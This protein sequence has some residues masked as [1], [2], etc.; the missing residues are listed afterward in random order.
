MNNQTNQ[1]RRLRVLFGRL[2]QSSMRSPDSSIALV[3]E[4]KNIRLVFQLELVKN[5]IV[6][7]G[8]S[9]RKK[10]RLEAL[11]VRLGTRSQVHFLREEE[12][13]ERKKRLARTFLWR[14]VFV[15]RV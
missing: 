11:C 8:F 14:T 3:N 10:F 13:K 12:L 15:N 9:G 5:G 2:F 1:I 7:V 4:C 6:R